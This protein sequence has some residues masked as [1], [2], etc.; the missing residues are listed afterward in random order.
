MKILANNKLGNN[1]F[2]SML[3]NVIRQLLL[4][5]ENSLKNQ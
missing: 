5:F 2:K 1:F 4:Q 3:I